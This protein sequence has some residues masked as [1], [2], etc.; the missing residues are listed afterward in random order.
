MYK[1]LGKKRITGSKIIYDDIYNNNRKEVFGNDPID[2]FPK[3]PL[4]GRTVKE[5]N[6]M[7]DEWDVAADEEIDDDKE[8]LADLLRKSIQKAKIQSANKKPLK[9][10]SLKD[11]SESINPAVFDAI[12]DINNS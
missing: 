10:E 12:N 4:G 5:W 11:D 9:D 3:P 6:D 8:T 7:Y 1:K 2:S